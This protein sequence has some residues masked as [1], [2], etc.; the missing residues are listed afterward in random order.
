[1]DLSLFTQTKE[2][3]QWLAD[4][5]MSTFLLGGNILC[6]TRAFSSLG[7]DS[8]LN[9]AITNWASLRFYK[10]SLSY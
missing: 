4:M 1:M 7:F 6:S 3:R 2:E 10:Q 8:V 9:L 5:M